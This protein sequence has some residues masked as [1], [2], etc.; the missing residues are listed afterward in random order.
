MVMAFLFKS[1]FCEFRGTTHF[2]I[3]DPWRAIVSN[4]F[5]FS[6]ACLAIIGK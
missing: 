6:G 2:E 1:L 3:C 5:V 4:S